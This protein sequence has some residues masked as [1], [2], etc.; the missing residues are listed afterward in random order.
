MSFLFSVGLSDRDAAALSTA[1]STGVLSALEYLDVSHNA[2]SAVGKRL[3]L[4]VQEE[5]PS[6]PLR[7]LEMGWNN[8]GQ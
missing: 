6:H 1:I 2:I 8:S 5:T 3:L 7:Y 4:R